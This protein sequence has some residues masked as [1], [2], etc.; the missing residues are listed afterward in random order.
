MHARAT[1]ERF[2][3]CNCTVQDMGWSGLKTRKNSR[4]RHQ[5]FD[6]FIKPTRTF[7]IT[8][9]ARLKRG[10]LCYCQQSSQCGTFLIPKIE[11]VPQHNSF[12]E[13]DSRLPMP[14]NQLPFTA[15]QHSPGLRQPTTNH[16]N[17]NSV[18]LE[19]CAKSSAVSESH[20]FPRKDPPYHF[21]Q[22]ADVRFGTSV[23]HDWKPACFLK[24]PRRNHTSVDVGRRTVSFKFRRPRH[25]SYC[26]IHRRLTGL[27]GR[28]VDHEILSPDT[29]G[30][31]GLQ[32]EAAVINGRPDISAGAI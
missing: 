15:C 26:W 8:E 27:A 14:L 32:A 21:F 23:P 20:N 7:D 25:V 19:L 4:S 3:I 5:Q 29:R 9:S 22:N 24:T 2:L 11:E 16:S 13:Y 1:Q 18:P 17:T 28:L 30:P 10:M 6:V 31:A 12:G